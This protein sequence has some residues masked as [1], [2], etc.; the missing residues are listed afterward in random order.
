MPR[1]VEYKRG[2]PKPDDRDQVQLCAQALCLEEMLRVAIPQG[3]LFYW[4][5]RRRDPVDFTPGLRRRVRELAAEMH[6]LFGSRSN[7][8]PQYDARCRLCSMANLCLPRLHSRK[9]R[10]VRR[11]LDGAYEPPT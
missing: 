4:Q 3:D 8:L 1:P 5:T 6:A 11:Y 7:P 9:A 10:S 2:K